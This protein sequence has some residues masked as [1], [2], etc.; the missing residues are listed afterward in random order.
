MRNFKRTE[1]FASKQVSMMAIAAALMATPVHALPVR[2]DV[3]PAGAVDTENVWAGVGQMY[4]LLPN[5]FVGLCTAQLIN[6]RTVILAAH[7]VDNTA[8]EGY[9]ALTGGQPI[10]FGFSVE[11]NFPGDLI[12]WI[13]GG[14]ASQPD[15]N[16][17]NVLQV[18]TVKNAPPGNFPLG[19]VAMA[20][21]STAIDNLPTYGMLFSPLDGPTR[22]TL[23]G[24]GGTGTGSAGPNLGIDFKRRVG[25]NMIDGLFSQNDYVA[26]VFNVPGVSFGDPSAEQLLYHID[27]DRPDRDLNDC[28]RGEFFGLGFG[29][30]I[31][32]FT[33]PTTSPLTWDGTSAITVNDQIDWFPGDALPNEAGTA[34]GDSG[35]GLFA[36]EIYERPLVT[37]VLSGGWV[38]GFFDPV[39]GYGSESYYTPLFLFRDWIQE[40][41]PYVYASARRGSGN[42][43]DPEHWQQTLDPNYFYIDE[44]GVVRNGVPSDPE[45]GELADRPKF[46]TVFDLDVPDDIEGETGAAPA[47]AA[48]A[49]AN[50]EGIA[51]TDRAASVAAPDG[52]YYGGGSGNPNSTSPAASDGA[53]T[54]P[55]ST[56]FTP[57]NDWG[58]FGAWTGPNDGVARFYDITLNN[59]G[60]TRV[61]MNAEIDRLT[62]RGNFSRLKVKSDYQ[63]NALIAVDQYR[64][65][66]D[67]D[68]VLETREYA[69]WGGFLSGDGAINTSTLYNIN[70]IVTAGGL[71]S[72]GDLTVNGDYVQSSEGMMLINIRRRGYFGGVSN[73]FIQVNGE[74]SLA[75]GALVSGGFFSRPRWRDSYTVLNAQTVVGNFDDV[76]LLF[77]SPIL[78]GDSIV[79]TN[80]DVDIVIK[81][82][83]FRDL[84]GHDDSLYSL[85]EALDDMRWGG[86]FDSLEGIF[87]FVDGSNFDT[88]GA[89]MTSLT[90]TA[91]FS[92]SNMVLNF[93]AGFTGHLT[94]RGAELRSGLRGVSFNGLR[95]AFVEA[96]RIQGVSSARNQLTQGAGSPRPQLKDQRLGLFV[97]SRGF[98]NVGADE[99]APG[100]GFQNPMTAFDPLAQANPFQNSGSTYGDIAIGADY[101]LASDTVIGVALSTSTM[102][103]T[104]G[105]AGP[106]SNSNVGAAIY[107]TKYGPRWYVDGYYGISSHDFELERTAGDL[108]SELSSREFANTRSAADSV[109]SM[110]GI[111]AGYTFTPVKGLTLGP[112]AT[113]AY[114]NATFKKFQ[115]YSP[116][117]LNLIVDRRNLT[118]LAMTLGAN[119]RYQHVTKKGKAFS[120][121]SD[122]SSAYELGDRTEAITAAFALAPEN[123]FTVERALDGDWYS[124]SAG[125]SYSAGGNFV[126]SLQFGADV[127]RGPLNQH[128]GRL[129]VD[130]RF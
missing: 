8:D 16:L 74:A 47:A 7:C 114:S 72:V 49:A 76:R 100:A 77:A 95:T 56:G 31:V 17:Y 14:F 78:F 126:T 13:N 108:A 2:D 116:S 4:N 11:N 107:A 48:A 57:N 110:A 54:G 66:V 9:G 15:I 122:F 42:W 97:S 128:Y 123:S 118:S 36:D 50:V 81:A 92:Q 63:L 40:N 79:Q 52:Y 94:A 23:V 130:W 20:S 103:L 43:S 104:S 109:Q 53:P 67:V 32:C 58:A 102:N 59:F 120:F 80:G 27:F 71:T 30:D 124:A 60:T 129:S 91:A 25:E 89:N 12:T 82:R 28:A 5:G 73:D 99:L 1:F 10:S 64:G 65:F 70:G 86:D 22:A 29:N 112:I 34:G 93:N 117:E 45:P 21:F 98:Q 69:L 19:D 6:P 111:R 101:R 119:L 51:R 3:G 121:Y 84:F 106:V 26:G 96:E 41:N 88:F 87:D 83:R 125:M 68:G 33:G 18:Q 127:D 39:G 61:D 44:Y 90:P 38:S 55:G 35:G 24:Y 62:V 37:G 113:M 105:G 115:E 85:G 46:G 75:G